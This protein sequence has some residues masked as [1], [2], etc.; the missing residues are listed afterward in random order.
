MKQDH[1]EESVDHT[2]GQQNTGNHKT[3]GAPDSKGADTL[4][5]TRTGAENVEPTGGA[6]VHSRPDVDRAAE[7]D[8]AP[9][10]DLTNEHGTHAEREPER[11]ERGRL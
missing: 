4:G 11:D 1:T 10:A 9:A 2:D 8:T 6:N 7:L 5:G 3:P